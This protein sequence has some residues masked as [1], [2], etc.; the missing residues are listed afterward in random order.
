M[1]NAGKKHKLFSQGK[2]KIRRLLIDKFCFVNLEKLNDMTTTL[3][4]SFSVQFTK[5]LTQ[6]LCYFY[7]YFFLV[8]RAIP[9]AYGD[10]QVRGYSC[11][12]TPQPKQYRIQATS[13]ICLHHSS[14]QCWILNPLKRTGIQPTTSWLLVRFVSAVPQIR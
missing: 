4:T 2:K 12:P 6:F 13:V 7:F 8:F 10:S 9:V 1:T 11:Q 14:Q 5:T 3:N